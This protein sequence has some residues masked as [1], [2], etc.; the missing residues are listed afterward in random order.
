MQTKEKRLLLIVAILLII[1]ALTFTYMKNSKKKNND[2][3]NDDYIST[4]LL[5]KEYNLDG[6]KITDLSAYMDETSSKFAAKATNTTN[7]EVTIAYLDI[8]FYDEND[9]VLG[10]YRCLYNTK[11]NPNEYQ[12]IN[13]DNIDY[14]K[15]INKIE[16]EIE[17]E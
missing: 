10:S 3:S 17:Y 4:E 9:Y 13:L 2:N 16:F 14:L 7:E 1:F 5:N 8:I 15:E 12:I 11:I 6:L